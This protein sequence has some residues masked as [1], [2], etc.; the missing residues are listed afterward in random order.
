MGKAVPAL[1][2]RGFV[3]GGPP[4]HYSATWG[5]V[6]LRAGRLRRVPFVQITRME[7]GQLDPVNGLRSP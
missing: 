4:A 2:H 1:T 5:R 7:P 6:R 3:T